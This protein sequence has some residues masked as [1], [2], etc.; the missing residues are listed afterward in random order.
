VTAAALSFDALSES[1]HQVHQGLR[2][3][4]LHGALG[5]RFGRVHRL[6][7]ATAAEAVRALCVVLPGFEAWLLKHSEPGYRVWIDR[8]PL[9]ADDLGQLVG[10]REAVRIAPVVSGAKR[11]G[12]GQIIVGSVL[13]VAGMVMTAY[14]MPQAGAFVTK[15]GV[16][17]ILGGVVQMLSP[18]SQKDADNGSNKSYS[19]GSP[20][21]TVDEGGP[22]PLAYGRVWAGSVVI[23]GGINT[24][25]KALAPSTTTAST[26]AAL[27]V[28][29]PLDPQTGGE[30][31]G[32]LSA[33]AGDSS[34]S[35]GDASTAGAGE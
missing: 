26:P 3:I 9:C 23:S 30:S 6:A 12:L 20:E 4:R 27:P 13:V 10:T 5:K 31:P 11:A 7:V 33:S 29:Q 21:N 16:V 18:Q 2:E 8:H 35:S 32:G 1:E 19:F 15:M 34:A 25:D 22:V 28:E 14:G 24:T 17:M